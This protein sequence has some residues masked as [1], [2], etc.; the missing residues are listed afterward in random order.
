M[1][2]FSTALTTYQQF[3]EQVRSLMLSTVDLAGQPQASYAPFIADDQRC[4]YV[5]VSGLSAHT[6]HLADSGRASVLLMVD[7]ADSPQIFARQRLSYNCQA[8]LIERDQPQW[9][10]LLDQFQQRFGNIITVLRDLQDFRLF[11]LTPT[12]GRFVM[13]FGAAYSVD[14]QDLHQLLPPQPPA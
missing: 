5:Y 4:L 2:D 10:P 14:P 7:E 1:A 3:M 11:C 9:S 6:Q 12:A 8:S 13:G